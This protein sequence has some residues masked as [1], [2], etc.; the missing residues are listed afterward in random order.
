MTAPQPFNRRFAFCAFLFAMMIGFTA[1]AGASTKTC[2]TALTRV[3]TYNIRLDTPIDGLDSW[4]HRRAWVSAQIDWLRPGIFGLQEVVIHQKRELASDLPGYQVI[5]KGRDV[6]G[7]GESSPIGFRS[8]LFA[9]HDSGVFW[10][11]ATPDIPSK[12]WD[13]AY[14]RIVTWAR[15]TANGGLTHILVINTHW[16]HIGIEARNNSGLQLQRWISDYAK[17]DDHVILLGDFNAEI[18][19]EAMQNLLAPAEV[20]VRLVDSRAA[21]RTK[22]FGPVGTFNDFKLK[23]EKL[24][25]IDH[26]LASNNISVR[27]HAVIAQNID[28][29]L[30]S[31][32]YPVLADLAFKPVCKNE[33]KAE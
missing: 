31:D 10:L 26:I 19:S 8:D 14:P 9:L 7:T 13:A 25:S 32:H 24:R 21:S 28:G 16:D 2:E 11:S 22:S 23:P 6:D 12:G 17:A 33:R 30:P 3:M 27:R 29:R 5:G 18:G 1:P 20:S 4:A 15:L